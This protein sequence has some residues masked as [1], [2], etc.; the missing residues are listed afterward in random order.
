MST[1]QGMAQENIAKHELCYGTE[2]PWL[3]EN[4]HTTSLM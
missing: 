3:Q 2:P 4:T 1:S